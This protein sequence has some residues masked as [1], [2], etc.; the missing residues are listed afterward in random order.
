M[1][2][3]I[4]WLFFAALSL[5]APALAQTPASAGYSP[6]ALH[7]AQPNAARFPNVTLFAYPTDSRGL[8]V[9]GLAPGDFR[10]L[11]N[12]RPASIAELKSQGGSIDVC[13][14]L[15]RSPSMLDEGKLTHAKEAAR[16]FVAQLAPEDQAALITFANGSTLDQ[17]LTTD[18]RL[19]QAAIDHTQVAGETTTFFDAVYW[20]VAQ[21]SL[22][23]PCTGNILPTAP[24]RSDAHRVVV[25]LT[26][27]IDKS[28]RVMTQELLDYAHAN[29]VSLCMIAVGSDASTT[30]MKYLADQ[31]GGIYMATQ[32]PADLEAL[33]TALARQL[34]REYRITYRSP[35]PE[36]DGT[37]RNVRLQVAGGIGADTW[38]NAPTQGSLVAAVS[39]APPPSPGVTASGTSTSATAPSGRPG[40]GVGLLLMAIGLAGAAGATGAWLAT[41]R[42]GLAIVDS[43]PQLDLLPLWVREGSTR[44]GR[45]A[46]CEVVLDSRQVSRVH[47]IIEAMDG[48][49]QLVD[50]GSHN[51]TY[52]NG[53][54]VRSRQPLQIGDRVRFGDREFRFAGAMEGLTT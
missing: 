43:N 49:Y 45:G 50:E 17:P 4:S 48:A 54:R 28:S 22:R 51:G 53:K 38:Y 20:A 18:K 24:G 52:V 33:Y 3:R 21:V 42:K 32:R 41:R 9:G 44:V 23:A 47:A 37:R 6:A 16:Q 25:A 1:N 27:G 2:R 26:D 5:A 12:G 11:E 30:L 46:E 34:R 8:L 36:A 19:L 35:T 14:A 40:I 39:T 7:A 15:D 10:V 31:T 29:G 13:L